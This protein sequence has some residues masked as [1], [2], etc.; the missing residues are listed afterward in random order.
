MNRL[1]IIGNGFD[2]AH[3]LK[4]SYNDFISWYL[5]KKIGSKFD[6]VNFTKMN[7]HN[8]ILCEIAT[9]IGGSQIIKH[10]NLLDRI[11]NNGSLL[12]KVKYI[13]PLLLN[14]ANSIENK[15]WVDIEYIYYNLLKTSIGVADTNNCLSYITD[16]LKEYLE[17]IQDTTISLDYNDAVMNVLY[18]NI[19]KSDFTGR[20]QFFQNHIIQMEGFDY[21][22]KH[23]CIG[24]RID[25]SN[26]HNSIISKLKSKD[27]SYADIT[28]DPVLLDLLSSPN[29][30]LLL[31][32]NYTKTI[33]IYRTEYTYNQ[34]I[35]IHG[36]L[37]N[38]GSMIFGYGDE[39][40]DSYK[41]LLDK[42]DNK[43][44]EF[45]KSVRYLETDNYNQLL[46]FINSDAFQTY[47]IGHSC[48]ISD[49]T[50][51][52]TIFDNPNCVSIKPFYYKSG[53]NDNYRD[54]VQNLCRIFSD[55]KRMREI[56]V[57]KTKC[58]P[59]PQIDEFRNSNN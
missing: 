22:H 51:L 18:G 42:N 30:V 10:R 44:L 19:K 25:L 2:L 29:E 5:E 35:S 33:N 9:R 40:D 55:P 54:I 3:G 23:H 53:N 36:S 38:R 41:M 7:S 32:F 28:G 11:I 12:L 6:S 17:S 43:Y 34:L 58:E 1:I 52:R 56:V 31:S 20:E 15:K 16:L 45:I 14:I 27:F 4:T 48:G 47:I 24:R 21:S 49:K 13:S 8:D 37:E 39:Y 50:L 57:D 59:F 46:S 26:T